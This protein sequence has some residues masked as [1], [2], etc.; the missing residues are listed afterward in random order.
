MPKRPQI[1]GKGADVFFTEPQDA[2]RTL[3]EKSQT[4]KGRHKGE[5][6]KR[7]MATFYLEPLVA[8]KLDRSWGERRAKGQKV[9][10]SEIVNEALRAYLKI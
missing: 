7:V 5:G 9:Q 10:K 1:K 8:D 3:K 4:T 2:Q 6:E